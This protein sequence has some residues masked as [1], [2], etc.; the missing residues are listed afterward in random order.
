MN[1]TRA[2]TSAL[3]PSQWIVTASPSA[4]F[5]STV[6]GTKNRTLMLPGGRSETTGRPAGTISPGR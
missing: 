3:Q 6:S 5:G 4:T 1:V 2:G